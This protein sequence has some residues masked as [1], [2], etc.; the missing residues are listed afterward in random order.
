VDD[1]EARVRARA[2]RLWLQDGRPPG[3]AEAYHDRA[4]ELVAIEDNPMQTRKPRPH[5]D[6]IGPSG[7]PVESIVPVESEA[8]VPTLTD[9]GEESTHPHKR[10]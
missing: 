10:R 3:S 4:R 7:E 5:E 2:H 6:T 8:G 9:Q 1:V